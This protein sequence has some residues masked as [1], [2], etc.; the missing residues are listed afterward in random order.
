MEIRENGLDGEIVLPPIAGGD[1]T[2]DVGAPEGDVSPAG[3]PAGGDENQQGTN[4]Q[5]QDDGRQ[6]DGETDQRQD[7]RFD[8]AGQALLDGQGNGTPQSIPYAR[9]AES[10]A[11]V[12]ELRGQINKLIERM[13][14]GESPRRES[15]RKAPEMPEH[16]RELDKGMGGYMQHYLNPLAEHILAMRDAHNQ[17]ITDFRDESRFY[18]GAGR[19]L[20]E[21]QMTLVESTREALSQ[22]LGQHVE[23]ADALMFLRGHPQ[24][25]QHFVDRQAQDSRD[26]NNDVVAARRSA[27]TVARRGTMRGSGE[28]TVDLNSMPRSQRIAHFERVMGDQPV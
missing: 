20:S 3:D 28:Q 9:F 5:G 13:G 27:G 14:S 15:E 10:R 23:R 22:K 1:E 12:R 11:E 4:D 19:N 7:Q 6:Q 8:T 2:V 25:G 21:Q 17:A 26:L 18:R 16:Y 24:Y